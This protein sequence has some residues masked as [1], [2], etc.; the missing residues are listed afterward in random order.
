M[1][2]EFACTAPLSPFPPN[3]LTIERRDVQL[4]NNSQFKEITPEFLKAYFWRNRN[5]LRKL[6][7]DE[8]IIGSSAAIK[9]E[10]YLFTDKYDIRKQPKEIQDLA[11]KILRTNEDVGED[12][13]ASIEWEI[14]LFDDQNTK[15]HD[16]S[17]ILV[18]FLQEG[19]P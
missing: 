2:G 15:N 10:M 19:T 12:L 1:E 14:E 16:E 17:L 9:L 4:D 11:L 18:P 8:D 7:F 6:Y 13:A 5:H 3:S